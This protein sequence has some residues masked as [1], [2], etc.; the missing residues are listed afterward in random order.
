MSGVCASR[1]SMKNPTD[2]V[3]GLVKKLTLEDTFAADDKRISIAFD[4][5]P[6]A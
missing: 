1:A 5:M 3:C 4:L 2:A 6:E